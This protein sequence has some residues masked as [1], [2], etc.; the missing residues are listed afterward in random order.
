MGV[1]NKMIL[2]IL[3]SVV[4]A[5]TVFSA[6]FGC[7]DYSY[8]LCHDPPA[9]QELHVG[10]LAEC[11]QNCDLFATFGQCDYLLYWE[12]GSGPDE[13]CKIISGPGTNTDEMAKY[14][15]QCGVIG[16]PMT[17]NGDQGGNCIWSGDNVCPAVC[18]NKCQDYTT[19]FQFCRLQMTSNP[20]T[21]FAY[22]QESKECI[23]Y[24]QAKHTC[25][26][27]VVLQGKTVDDVNTC[28]HN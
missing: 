23:C 9:N 15:G 21:Y 16:Q 14:L 3:I 10:S 17:D 25:S 5:T 24:E 20:W 11:I 18:G 26:M 12:P 8:N 6:D 7:G 27:T 13:N 2:T 19:C 28:I 22:N 1:Q 4:F